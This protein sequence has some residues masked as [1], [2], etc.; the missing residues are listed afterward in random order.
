MTVKGGFIAWSG[1]GDPNASI[2]TL[3]SVFYRPMFAS[4]GGAPAPQV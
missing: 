1:M 4:F 2:P 3:R